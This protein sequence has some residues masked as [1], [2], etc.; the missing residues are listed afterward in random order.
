MK[1]SS[2]AEALTSL[3]TILHVRGV[4]AFTARMNMSKME[5]VQGTTEDAN[6]SIEPL[7]EALANPDETAGGKKRRVRFEEPSVKVI[8]DVPDRE[9]FIVCALLCSVPIQTRQNNYHVGFI[10]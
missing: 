3:I 8:R 6:T 9:C 7:F 2:G 4:D 10:N 5:S 1:M